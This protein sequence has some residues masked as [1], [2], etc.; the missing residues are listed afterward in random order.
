MSWY[1][2][3]ST[4]DGHKLLALLALADW[5]NDEGE[6]YP[7]IDTIAKRIRRDRRSAQRVIG[8]L[9]TA[10]ELVIYP[11]MGKGADGKRSSLYYLVRF[12]E[13]HKLVIP[14]MAKEA[15]E[16]HRQIDRKN[17]LRGLVARRQFQLLTGDT[18]AAPTGDTDAAPTGDMGAAP[19]GDMGAAPT[20]DTRVTQNHQLE[21]S[22]RTVSLEPP[23]PCLERASSSD[24]DRGGLGGGGS[25]FSVLALEL[26]QTHF[27]AW[28]NSL[29]YVLSLTDKQCWALCTWL[30][31]ERLLGW[32]QTVADYTTDRGCD[33]AAYREYLTSKADIEATYAGLFAG[34]NNRIGLIR[35]HVA[36][37]Y[38]APLAEIDLEAL[39]EE[40]E[41]ATASNS[42]G[43]KPPGCAG[44]VPD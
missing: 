35:K 19:T 28:N 36:T 15:A 23:P 26:I 44:D 18:D 20:G 13:T 17:G 8:D 2:E 14:P 25:G 5:S 37:H 33:M 29:V 38:A 42:D 7:S 10:G 4:Q 27:P 21:P 40:A 32:E 12:R 43:T 16:H 39:H 22:V 1:W 30:W 9:E 31:V 41:H 24:G 3:H 6:C 34:I 11:G